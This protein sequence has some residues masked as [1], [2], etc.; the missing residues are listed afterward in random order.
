MQKVGKME[1]RKNRNFCITRV[2]DMARTKQT[3]KKA[4][5]GK[6][7]RRGRGG[8]KTPRKTYNRPRSP[9]YP[10]QQE[11]QVKG[12]PRAPNHP[13]HNPHRF[14]PGTGKQL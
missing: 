9:T 10:P 6:Q 2:V 12:V 14:R 4:T 11:R 5:G 8:K 13:H 1:K 7:P 3:A